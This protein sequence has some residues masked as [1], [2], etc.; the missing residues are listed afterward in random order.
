MRT[1]MVTFQSE[2]LQIGT[3]NL[4]YFTTFFLF[5]SILLLQTWTSALPTPITV[6]WMQIV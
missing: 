2:S 3:F 6:T 4:I 1:Q 5:L